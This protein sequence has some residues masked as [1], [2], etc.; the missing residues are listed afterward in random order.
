MDM[1]AWAELEGRNLGTAASVE[2]EEFLTTGENP[3]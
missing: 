2:R 1:P 3:Q